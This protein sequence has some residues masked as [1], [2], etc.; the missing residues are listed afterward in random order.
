MQTIKNFILR[1]DFK[2]AVWGAVVVTTMFW[3]G[4][5]QLSIFVENTRQEIWQ[6]GYEVGRFDQ[7]NESAEEQA[8]ECFN[9]SKNQELN[10]LLKKYFKDCKL[11]RTIYAIAQA[12]SNGKQF[13]VGQND[14]GTMDGGW[15]QVNSV[16]R[17]AGETQIAFIN[18]M[19][20]LEQNIALAKLVYDKQGLK[21]WVTYNTGKYKQYLK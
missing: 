6:E 11:A 12:E 1:H 7:L 16:H 2:K 3:L 5:W 13:A 8:N 10:V 20:N 18:R 14:N 19:H 17:N 9:L 21:A 15:L 4:V